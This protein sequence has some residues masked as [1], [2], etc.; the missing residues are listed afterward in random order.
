ML[1][2]FGGN[3]TINNIK[4]PV[5]YDF[6]GGMVQTLEETGVYLGK[7]TPY[8]WPLA[9]A[10]G[11]GGSPAAASTDIGFHTFDPKSARVTLKGYRPH[12]FRGCSLIVMIVKE[13]RQCISSSP[14][15]VSRGL[16]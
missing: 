10:G 3:I 14:I 12:G 13:N 4:G 15:R 11:M 7:Y 9:Y 8:G 6:K 16:L 1:A 2:V 5:C